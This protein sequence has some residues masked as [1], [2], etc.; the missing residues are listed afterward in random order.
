MKP[1]AQGTAEAHSLDGSDLR[2]YSMCGSIFVAKGNLMATLTIKNVPRDLHKRL[3]E[4]A[5]QHHRSVNGEVIA[6][7]ERML[8]STPLDPEEVL[9]RARAS[10]ERTPRIF[11][12]DEDLRKMKNE[13]RL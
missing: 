3:K 7:L 8:I 4:S 2:G 11:L 13:G 6:C 10:R 5:E 1:R 9:R 12:T